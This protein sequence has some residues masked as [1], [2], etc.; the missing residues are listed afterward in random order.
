MT[1]LPKAALPLLLAA[2]TVLTSLNA[3]AHDD[4]QK[5][6]Y[7]LAHGEDGMGSSNSIHMPFMHTGGDEL[8]IPNLRNQY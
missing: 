4:A 6:C 3:L 7:P 8:A 1:T 5:H 2:S